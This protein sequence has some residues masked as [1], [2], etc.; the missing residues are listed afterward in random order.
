MLPAGS[1][2][3]GP[4]LDADSEVRPHNFARMALRLFTYNNHAGIMLR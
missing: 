4:L 2:R 1:F 3:V